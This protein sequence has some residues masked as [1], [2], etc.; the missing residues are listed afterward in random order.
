MK[1]QNKNKRA[2][3]Y[4]ESLNSQGPERTKSAETPFALLQNSL[5]T[6]LTEEIL[7]EKK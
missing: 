5:G 1:L 3:K 4:I 6:D 2:Y 7:E